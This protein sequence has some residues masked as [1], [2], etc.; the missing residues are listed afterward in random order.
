MRTRLAALLFLV[1]AISAPGS[2]WSQ[3]KVFACV[4]EWASLA[5]ELGG[6]KVTITAVA[7]GALQD[8]DEVEV[9]PA[10]LKSVREANLAVCTGPLEAGWL[11]GLLRR[12][13]NTN[14]RP[15][16]N[17]Y[18]AA[19]DYVK[20]MAV[21]KRPD[22]KADAHAHS[23]GH[24]HIQTDPR[25]IRAVAV[26]LGRKLAEIDPPNAAH[27]N[28]RTRAFT[29]RL[30]AA[31]KRWEEQAAPLK[32]INVIAQHDNMNYLFAW[33]GINQVTNVE[34]TP[35]Q[36]PPPAHL[37]KVI[38]MVGPQKVRF[39]VNAAY[40]EPKSVAYVAERAKV[41]LAT[42]AFTVGGTPAAK[43]LFTLFDDMIAGML[44][45]AGAGRS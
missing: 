37:A 13:G 41:P 19:A 23:S 15:G 29:D 18:F 33:L 30:D 1:A 5:Q 14:V 35:A 12:A 25:N 16:T 36:A 32:G 34:L 8:P 11:P 40:E 38:D 42:L 31:I 22:A 10:L 3:V 39:I 28:T 20:M 45:A 24:P 17:G 9:K 6:D 4:P 7:A 27:Y 2:A 21:P 44:Q 43:D 26:Q